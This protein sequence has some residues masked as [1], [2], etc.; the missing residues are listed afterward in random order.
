MLLEIS[1]LSDIA[2]ISFWNLIDLD[3]V[4]GIFCLRMFYASIKIM[5]FA[6]EKELGRHLYDSICQCD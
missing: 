3:S 5:F 6:Q 2:I 1:L 4:R